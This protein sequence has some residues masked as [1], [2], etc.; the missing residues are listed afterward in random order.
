MSRMSE[1]HGELTGHFEDVVSEILKKEL[2]SE[3]D[4]AGFMID[5]AIKWIS[6]MDDGASVAAFR[7]EQGKAA[8]HKKIV[9]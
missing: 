2:C 3:I 9:D 7:F 8:S 6:S 5:Y 1:I 4:I